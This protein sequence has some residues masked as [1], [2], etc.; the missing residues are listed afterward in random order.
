[1]GIS[2]RPV[3][4]VLKLYVREAPQEKFLKFSLPE[5]PHLGS[6][7]KMQTCQEKGTHRR[8][9]LTL[10]RVTGSARPPPLIT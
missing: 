1:M 8:P 4:K 6:Q 3:D 10:N 5:N 9:G 2:A 7:L